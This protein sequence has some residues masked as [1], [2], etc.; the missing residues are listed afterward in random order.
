MGIDMGTSN[1]L[2]YLAG[3]GIMLNEP[4]VMAVHALSEE[5]IAIGRD[6]YRMLGRTSENLKVFCPMSNGV[7]SD[8]RYTQH[9]MREY[10]HRVSNSAVFNPRVVLCVPGVITEVE[11][12]AAV[13]ALRVAGARRICLL[14]ETIAAAMGAGMDVTGPTGCGIID[15]GGG[16]ADMAVI[17]LG[18]IASSRSCKNAGRVMDEAVMNMVRSTH[19]LWIGERTAEEAKKAIGCAR[20]PETPREF[21]VRGRDARTGLPASRV[22]TSEEVYKA[23]QPTIRQ[24][25]EELRI[26]L[27]NTPPEL[28][29]DLY[30]HGML[31]TGGGALLDGMDEVLSEYACLHVRRAD[32]PT[33]CVALGAGMS[34]KY[35]ND[36]EDEG[37]G[38]VSPLIEA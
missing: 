35:L 28:V 2:I 13:N 6:A 11:R 15:I 17:S 37:R 29:G 8:Y 1:T 19:G 33:E 30:E 18:G 16:T 14:D 5:I 23:L 10:I 31:L 36:T 32:N 24:I 7:I 38:F 12:R 26:L 34:L 27:E 22:I 25:G 4:S 3:K 21:T 20:L 9:M